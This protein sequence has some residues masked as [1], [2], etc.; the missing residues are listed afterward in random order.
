[1]WDIWVAAFQSVFNL[2]TLLFIWGGVL[3]GV[4]LGAIP[5][6]NSTMGVAL[7]IPFT[8]AMNPTNGLALLAAVYC[9]G[10]YGGSIS[11]ILFN[12]PGAPEASATVFDGYQMAKKGQAAQALGYA[13]MCSCLGGLF[14]VLVLNLVAPELAKVAL[15]FSQPE[16]FAL[17]VT[18]LTLIASLGARGMKKAAISGAFGLLAATVGIDPMTSDARFA[19]GGKSLIGGINFIPAIIGAFAVGEVLSRAET[20]MKKG[21]VLTK[22]ISTILPR[23]KDIFRMK[24]LML[25]S[26]IIGTWI[27]ILPGVGATTAAFVGYAEA[28]RWSKHPE[29]FGTGIPEGIAGPETANNAATGGAMVPLLTL[30]IPGSATTAVMIGGFLVHG[31]QPGPMLFMN[32]PKL[33]YSIFIAMYLANIFMLFAG[34]GVAK[35]FSNFAKVRYSLIGPCIFLFAAIG[36]FGIRNDLMDLW[37]MLFFGVIGYF[38]N[39]YG[40]PL[41]PMIIGLVLGPLTEISLRR[42]LRMT[43]FQL[44]PF[45]FRPIAGGIL[46][47]AII[48]IL[49]GIFR[50]KPKVMEGE[51]EYSTD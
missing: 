38:M 27:G 36:S 5:G 49:Y 45:F 26:A 17:A 40:Y 18:A 35:V 29:K 16:Y 41:A 30:G 39:K 9:G 22:K 10:T 31:L 1:M 8:Y 2:T 14:S 12:V 32:Q 7:L 3:L 50:K 19:F 47:I 33:M 37:I 21:E 42:G 46:I 13:V 48:S 44:A 43:D 6:L 4:V 24:W 51:E 34:L 11:A 20:G 28:V 23:V 25:R 15:T